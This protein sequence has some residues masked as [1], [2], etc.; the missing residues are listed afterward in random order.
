MTNTV[1]TKYTGHPDGGVSRVAR[2]SRNTPTSRK[3]SGARPSRHV[4]HGSRQSRARA[5]RS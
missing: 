2:W 3:L 1:V 5:T 4:I